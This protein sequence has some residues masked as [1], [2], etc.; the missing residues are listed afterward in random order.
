[1]VRSAESQA[2]RGLRNRAYPLTHDAAQVVAI[3]ATGESHADVARLYGTTPSAV[4]QFAQKN[5][6]AIT[7]IKG[8]IERRVQDY[9]IAQ[10][11]NRIAAL[12]DRWQRGQRVIEERAV[13]MD[14]EVAGGGTGLLVRQYKQI[15]SGKDAETVMEYKVDGGLMAELR[16]IERAAAEELDQLPKGDKGGDTYNVLQLVRYVQGNDGSVTP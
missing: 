4:T 15:G 12:N 5:A 1:M 2:K 9:H 3:L 7:A 16:A 14:G 13:E 8:E 11:V 10:Q 6:P